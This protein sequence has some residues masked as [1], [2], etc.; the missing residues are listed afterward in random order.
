M[1]FPLYGQ[2]GNLFNALGKM[3]A[4]V[5]NANS[6]Q[7][8][9]QT[10]LINSNTSL[11]NQLN[12]QPDIAATVG[13]GWAGWLA[14][15]ESPCG[16]MQ[17]LAQSYINRLVYVAQPQLNQT[18]TS[19]NLS[20]SIGYVYEQMISQGAT[21]LQMTVGSSTNP[22]VG[23]G[24][25]AITCS[26]KRPF[27]GRFLENAYAETLTF[28]C[29]ADSYVG[30]ATAFNEPFAVTGE[31]AQAD[32]FAYNWPLGSNS[33][34][35]I[36]AIDGDTSNGS[37]NYLTN[38]GFTTWSGGVP[39][40]WAAAVGATTLSQNQ[41][42]I[43]TP[44]S[45]LQI[46][47]D[48]TTLTSLTQALNSSTGSSSTLATQTQY[49]V[50]LFM[51]AGGAV[52]SQGILQ[53]DL[54]DGGGSIV[55]DQLGTANSFTIDLTKL[56]TSWQA[57]NGFFRTPT[58]LGTT[59]SIRVHLTTALNNGAVVY[60][61]KMSL[62]LAN[63]VYAQGPYVAC[64]SGNSLFVASPTADYATCT[65]TNSRGVGGTLNTFQTL[66]F[67]LLGNA[68]GTELLWPSSLSPNVSDAL[69]A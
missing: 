46:T 37:G 22:F 68:T 61:D 63:Q 56:G 42:I 45:S 32:V 60:L 16:S 50:N 31:G 12:G 39:N 23:M 59:Y 52:P 10:T 11:L 44:G 25:G 62:G 4:V 7:T 47:G 43:Y 35:S 36:N 1:A 30:G 27:D 19:N 8:T 66:L 28:T 26:L 69:I 6:A 51:R 13:T 54:I 48:G 55:S 3:G 2:V 20:A 5:A 53:V 38:S 24:N 29:T 17:Q 67:R 34:I 64:H 33:S 65:V 40:N 18:L 21:I 15:F 9:M 14:S 41:S 49:S 58:T 57:F